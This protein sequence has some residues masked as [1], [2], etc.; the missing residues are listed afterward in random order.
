MDAL[1][2]E[3]S[4]ACEQLLQQ[5]DWDTFN[6][7]YSNPD[8]DIQLPPASESGDGTF[9]SG[10]DVTSQQS[11]AAQEKVRTSTAVLANK[12]AAAMLWSAQSPLTLHMATT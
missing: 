8:G 9:G 12:S 5:S 2:I 11:Y 3:Q 7:L 4:R 6:L 1:D 10:A